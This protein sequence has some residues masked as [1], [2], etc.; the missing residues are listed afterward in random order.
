MSLISSSEKWISPV[1]L[2]V[3][4]VLFLEAFFMYVV[5]RTIRKPVFEYLIDSCSLESVPGE[6]YDPGNPRA[7]YF[8]LTQ[9]VVCRMGTKKS[10]IRLVLSNPKEHEFSRIN[11]LS[12][13]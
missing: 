9:E 6:G 3:I 2:T 7:N 8:L 5:Y 4:A 1:I 12:G 13:N 10:V 11:Q